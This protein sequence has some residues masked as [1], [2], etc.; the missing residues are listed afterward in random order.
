[1]E[2]YKE[3]YLEAFLE[4]AKINMGDLMRV[5]KDLEKRVR[6]CYAENITDVR[7]DDFVTMIL[8]DA[9]FII[10]FFLRHRFNEWTSEDHIVL[11]P[12]LTA[13]MQQDLILLENQLPFFIIVKLFD[14]AF[15]SKPGIPSFVVLTFEY[16]HAYNKQNMSPRPQLKILHFLDL[17]RNFFLPPYNR[18]PK[19]KLKTVKHIHGATELDAVGLKFEVDL[20]R[21]CLLDLDLHLGYKKRV[22]KIPCFTFDDN[23]ELHVRNLLA[24]E[25][26]H[27]P[28]MTYVTDH[29]IL[30]DFLIN[31]EE[32]LDLLRRQGIVVNGFGNKHATNFMGNLGTGIIHELQIL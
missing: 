23:T 3:K 8:T 17:L 12:W 11:K 18:L 19:R 24:L 22:L 4:R 16:F 21:N 28:N 20:S 29:F 26:C 14:L 5:V 27:Y 15:A 10:E 31:R 1:M 2:K 6:Q 13:R 30:L 7:S 25:Q 32:D 9:S